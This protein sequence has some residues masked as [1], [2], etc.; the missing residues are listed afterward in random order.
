MND[1]DTERCGGCKNYFVDARHPMAK[2]GFNRCKLL[3]IWRT[4]SPHARCSFYP[5]NW[6]GAVPDEPLKTP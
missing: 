4:L 3:P 6:T 5:S 1:L 2:F